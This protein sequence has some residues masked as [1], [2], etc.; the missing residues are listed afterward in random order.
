M[1]MSRHAEARVRQRGISTADIG[2]IWKYGRETYAP[3][4]AVKYFLGRKECRYALNVQNEKVHVVE[5]AKG[6]TL[7]LIDGMII[8]AYKA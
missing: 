5:N 7:V 6:G 8:T 4:G 1:E 3:G 2:I